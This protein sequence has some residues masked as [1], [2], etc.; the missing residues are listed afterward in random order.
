MDLCVDG[1]RPS[2]GLFLISNGLLRRP[3]FRV[4]FS[5]STYPA[6]RNC[7][8][9]QSRVAATNMLQ[10]HL[11]GWHPHALQRHSMQNQHAVN[12]RG[13]S[14]KNH[15][16]AAAVSDVDGVL[17]GES[18]ERRIFL[19]VSNKR[20]AVAEDVHG[21][22]QR[23]SSSTSRTL[24]D[25]LG[26]L[27]LVPPSP[28]AALRHKMPVAAEAGDDA[29]RRTKT[30]SSPPSGFANDTLGLNNSSVS[31]DQRYSSA[32]TTSFS[33]RYDISC[34]PSHFD[35][36]AHQ[37]A[38]FEEI[39]SPQRLQ[40]AGGRGPKGVKI[41][42][43]GR[44]TSTLS[45]DHDGRIQDSPS[46]VKPTLECF[47][48]DAS[49]LTLVQRMRIHGHP[50]SEQATRLRREADPGAMIRRFWRSSG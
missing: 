43:K 41:C 47:G 23:T 14:Y 25:P 10:V 4:L 37:T 32:V 8:S 11:F 19:P 24:A 7:Q 50:V 31:L 46:L 36:G 29:G 18:C 26:A 48:R 15:F 2:H 35:E 1:T 12:T 45:V 6:A 9:G 42:D 3:R 30:P 39:Y 21:A 28:Y 33:G 22:Q 5:V 13:A 27:G 38:S 44:P 17:F 34:R 20:N 49:T 16:P 40:R